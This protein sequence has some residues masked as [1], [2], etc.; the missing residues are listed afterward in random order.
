MKLVF[1]DFPC[2]KMD[3]VSLVP[4]SEQS[5]IAFPEDTQVLMDALK[6]LSPQDI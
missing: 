1:C 3:E 2:P 5:A 4:V 6:Q